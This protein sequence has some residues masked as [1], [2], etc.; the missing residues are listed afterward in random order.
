MADRYVNWPPPT[1]ALMPLIKE[2][3]RMSAQT[4]HQ[5]GV[6]YD[7]DD[8]D[9]ARAVIE[10]TFDGLFLSSPSPKGKAGY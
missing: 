3:A 7:M 9:V 1:E 8:P 2:M 5:T 10:A 4:A 6:E